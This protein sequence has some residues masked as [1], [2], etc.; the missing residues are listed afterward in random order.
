[1]WSQWKPAMDKA[2]R[3]AVVGYQSFGG[4]KVLQGSLVFVSRDV[5]EVTEA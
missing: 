1:M 2:L 4:L 5:W 3:R